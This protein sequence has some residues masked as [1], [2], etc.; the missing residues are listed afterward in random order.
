MS[1][2]DSSLTSTAAEVAAN[3]TSKFYEFALQSNNVGFA[4]SEALK[5]PCWWGYLGVLSLLL[6]LMKT[7]NE[8]QAESLL[9]SADDICGL[10]VDPF[11]DPFSALIRSLPICLFNVLV[12]LGCACSWLPEPI[13]GYHRNLACQGCFC[14]RIT[15][16]ELDVR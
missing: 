13:R 15:L 10:V 9:K 1:R 5:Y 14:S 16:L 4:A 11:V 8:M 12:S 6:A 2:F 7:N 3:I